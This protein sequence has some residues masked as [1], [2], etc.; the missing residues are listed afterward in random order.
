MRAATMRV[1]SCMICFMGTVALT[2]V[3]LIFGEER[4]GLQTFVSDTHKHITYNFKIIKDKLEAGVPEGPDDK[5]LSLLG[6]S[7]DSPPRSYP[8]DVWLNTSLPVVV[9]YASQSTLSQAIGLAR[10]VGHFLHNHSLL[11]YYIDLKADQLQTLATFCNSSRCQPLKFD[12]SQFPQHVSN[13]EIHAFRPLIIQDAVRKSGA[14]LYLENDQRLT[15]GDISNLVNTA[16]SRGVLTW[17]APVSVMAMTH[18][19]MLKFLSTTSKESVM[20]TPTVDSEESLLFTPM[21]D[22]S[23]L[24]VYNTPTV[25]KNILLPWV[26][27]TLKHDCIL[28]IGAQSVGCRFDKKPFYRYSGC[29]GYDTS[30]LSVLLGFAFKFESDSYSIQQESQSTE[31][32]TTST[33]V[34]GLPTASHSSY[35]RRIDPAE[36]AMELTSLLDNSTDSSLTL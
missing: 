25:S 2:L 4:P 28:P 9:S 32:V 3:F 21:V 17:R 8:D 12:L 16:S 7:P 13:E 5:Y 23:R 27:C 36:A 33:L 22:S 29:H 26:K 34:P 6:L 14:I 35:F 19:R 30:A 18:P 24:I 20:L 10:N 15:T 31:D 1:K 11:V